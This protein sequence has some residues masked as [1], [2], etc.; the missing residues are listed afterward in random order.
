[1]KSPGVPLHV[2]SISN[3]QRPIPFLKPDF[4]DGFPGLCAAGIIDFLKLVRLGQPMKITEPPSGVD[5]KIFDIQHQ[6]NELLKSL[7][8]LR[9]ECGAGL[10]I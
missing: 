7:D 5:R 4:W 9:S 10:K 6:E 1:M 8:Y 3:S 2:E